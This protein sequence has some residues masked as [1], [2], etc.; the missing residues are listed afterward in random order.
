MKFFINKKYLGTEYCEIALLV[1][2]SARTGDYGKTKFGL[3][4][5]YQLKKEGYEIKEITLKEATQISNE[6]KDYKTFLRAKA[7]PL[8]YAS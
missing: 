2:V 5:S 7:N 3:V 4:S 8:K 6:I 1:L